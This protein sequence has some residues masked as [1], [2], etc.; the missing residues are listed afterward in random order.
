MLHDIGKLSTTD[1]PLDRLDRLAH[2]PGAAQE[3]MQTNRTNRSEA[4]SRLRTLLQRHDAATCLDEEREAQRAAEEL[5]AHHPH[6]WRSLFWLA[7]LDTQVARRGSLAPKSTPSEPA[8]ATAAPEASQGSGV[9]GPED[10]RGLL[11]RAQEHL[12]RAR[13]AHPS[14]SARELSSFQALQ[15]LIHQLH[16]VSDESAARRALHQA[17]LQRQLAAAVRTDP[18]NPAVWVMLGIDFVVR[19]D[20]TGALPELL[21][22]HALLCRAH[23]ALQALPDR[24]R[25]TFFN[26][27]WVPFWLSRVEELL[28]AGPQEA[29]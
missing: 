20:Q 5:V 28:G 16:L 9:T 29:G 22:G 23:E 19:G 17:A 27:E 3:T 7:Y 14:P 12:N 13:L 8:A 1:L 10:R 2:A 18:H 11:A 4:R 6:C 21:A 25:T 15:A 26:A 24:S